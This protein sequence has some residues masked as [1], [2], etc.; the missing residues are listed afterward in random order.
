[1]RVWPGRF[2]RRG[3]IQFS[4]ENSRIQSQEVVVMQ[5]AISAALL[6]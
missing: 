2:W 4:W 3:S 6:T 5:G 1:M